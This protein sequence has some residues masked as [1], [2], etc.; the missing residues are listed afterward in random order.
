MISNTVFEN[1][2]F[3]DGYRTMSGGTSLNATPLSS[4]FTINLISPFTLSSLASIELFF[5]KEVKSMPFGI[6]FEEIS[7]D[8]TPIQY[9]LQTLSELGSK[10]AV[11]NPTRPPYSSSS[12]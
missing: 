5:G 3:T 11:T 6:C 7:P 8:L 4:P 9:P 12:V 10:S 1:L 2:Q